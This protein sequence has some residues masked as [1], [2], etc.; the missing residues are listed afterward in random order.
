VAGHA[1][2]NARLRYIVPVMPLFMVLA[3]DTLDAVGS[4]LLHRRRPGQG[5]RS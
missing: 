3:S 5:F 1:L 4:A 2:A